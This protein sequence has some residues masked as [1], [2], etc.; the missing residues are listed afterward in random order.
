MIRPTP[1]AWPRADPHNPIPAKA[2]ARMD[3]EAASIMLPVFRNRNN[4][5]RVCF[6]GKA[7]AANYANKTNGGPESAPSKAKL[8]EVSTSSS[9]FHAAVAPGLILPPSQKRGTGTAKRRRS[10]SPCAWVC[11]FNWSQ[12]S[13]TFWIDRSCA[14][15][16]RTAERTQRLGVVNSVG[17]F[18]AGYRLLA[19]GYHV[20]WTG[21]G[22]GGCGR[23][24]RSG[25]WR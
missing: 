8:L 2:D 7:L 12:I 11:F 9:L 4:L 5:R 21:P 3:C 6:F 24:C 16:R 22:A 15:K 14:R 25:A 23:W 19:P 20:R 10:Q 17:S 18:P 1:S 13:R